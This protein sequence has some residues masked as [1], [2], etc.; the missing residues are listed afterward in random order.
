M[1]KPVVAILLGDPTGV[2]PELAVKVLSAV[3][4]PRDVAYVI[5]GDKRVFDRACAIA[6]KAP[7]VAYINSIEEHFDEG[8][9]GF[10]DYPTIDPRDY[11]VGVLNV[12]GGVSVLRTLTYVLELAKNDQVQGI[13]FAPFN[14]QA[15]HSA[16]L[17]F[18]SELEYFKDFFQ[19]PNIPGEI[20]I[21][22]NL[23]VVR[24][25][26]HVAIKDVSS[27]LSREKIL[28]AIEFLGEQ[29]HAID[30]DSASIMVTGLNPHNGENG[31]FGNEEQEVIIP[32]ISDAQKKGMNV[33]GPY[34]ADT[35][36]T[37]IDKNAVSGLVCMYHDQAQIGL[38]LLGMSQGVSLHAG[39][40]I[41][42]ITPAHGTAFDIAGKNIVRTDAFNN[43]LTIIAAMVRNKK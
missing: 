37:R 11:E 13:I 29:F 6:E 9:I 34:P 43:A 31:L 14:K 27:L 23:W 7:P 28:Y 17:A 3:H 1:K 21:L 36:F 42:I 22:H 38:K 39:L 2:G 8:H 19:R 18:G 25:T 12:A 24:V 40:P 20:N 33:L 32:A 5:V 15:M 16:G 30:A 4:P 35:I 10:L 26:S 41:P